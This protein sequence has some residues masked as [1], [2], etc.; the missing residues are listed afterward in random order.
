MNT[1]TRLQVLIALLILNTLI[2][3]ITVICD[4]AARKSASDALADICSLNWKKFKCGCGI[5]LGLLLLSV[6]GVATLIL[7]RLSSKRT[8]NT[9]HKP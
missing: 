5:I 8:S 6:F 3:F 4:A 2:G 7:F 9:P 1:E